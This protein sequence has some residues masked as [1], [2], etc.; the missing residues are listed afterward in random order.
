[1]YLIFRILARG[2]RKFYR[3]FPGTSS[4]NLPQGAGSG[5]TRFA[6]GATLR[7]SPPL[8]VTIPNAD[9]V[10]QDASIPN[11][12]FRI[13]AFR[14]IGAPYEIIPSISLTLGFK[15]TV[16]SLYVKR[17][18]GKF[19]HPTNELSPCITFNRSPVWQI[20]HFAWLAS[21]LRPADLKKTDVD[22]ENSLKN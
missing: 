17:H 9:A 18:L 8:R 1:M 22:S 2:L 12:F 3:A 13:F 10:S 7:A 16:A 5:Y 15:R 6:H 11:Q 4:L 14:I 21:A 19:E 20:G